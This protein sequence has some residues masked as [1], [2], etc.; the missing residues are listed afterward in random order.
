ML[1]NGELPVYIPGGYTS[2]YQ[3]IGV[4]VNGPIKAHYGSKHQQWQSDTKSVESQKSAE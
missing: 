4:S 1:E 2:C 3:M